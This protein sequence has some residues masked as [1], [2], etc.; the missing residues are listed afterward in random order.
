MSGLRGLNPEWPPERW[1][2]PAAPPVP[3]GSRSTQTV[4]Q[5]ALVGPAHAPAEDSA[6][7][8]SAAPFE[9]PHQGRTRPLAWPDLPRVLP[10]RAQTTVLP[11][12]HAARPS[13]G[14]RQTSS[15]VC[16][17]LSSVVHPR[18]IARGGARLAA[19]APPPS[20]GTGR[21][22]DGSQPTNAVPA[23]GHR[24]L[25]WRVQALEWRVRAPQAPPS[26]SAA[27]PHG[28]C[29]SPLPRRRAWPESLRVC[30]S[31][32]R[33]SQGPRRDAASAS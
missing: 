19:R 32:W 16:H 8:R 9:C 2:L 30:P 11:E 7:G 17:R 6:R 21:P 31:P 29:R 5:P 18:V 24:D 14:R 33:R 1:E 12:S 22:T 20:L 25:E 10:A 23:L 4:P 27:T 13:D 3:W 28:H 15:V 26:S